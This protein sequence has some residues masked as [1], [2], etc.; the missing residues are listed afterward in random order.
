MYIP[1]G[2]GEKEEEES[3]ACRLNID[4]ARN[5]STITGRKNVIIRKSSTSFQNCLHCEIRKEPPVTE[6]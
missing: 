1:C 6:K 2:H 3:T 5:L 4:Y